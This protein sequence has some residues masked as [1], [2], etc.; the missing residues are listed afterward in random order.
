MWRWQ[1][2]E[3][4]PESLA[5]TDVKSPIA[6]PGQILV[7]VGAVSLNYRDKVAL[8]GGFGTGHALPVVPCSDAAGTVVAVGAGVHRFRIG[9]R[10]ISHLAPRWLHGSVRLPEDD[11]LLGIPLEGVL[12]EQIVLSAEGAVATPR[13]MDDRE[14]CTLPIAALT[15]WCAWFERCHLQ[16]G[17]TVVIQGTGG[18][19]LFALQFA[20]MAGACT[21]VTSSDNQKLE[22]VSALGARHTINYRLEPRWGLA[23]KAL[24]EGV[25]V[26][27]VLN[28]AGGASVMESL[29]ACRAGGSIVIAGL[30]EDAEF[31]LPILPFILQQG[32]IHTLSVGSR[33]AFEAM[34]RALEISE[35]KPVI[36]R[37]FLFSEAKAAF[38][39][40]ERGAFGKIVIRMSS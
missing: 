38:D 22:R 3:Y 23:A 30:L 19:A 8:E 40:L 9:D 16:P 35:I 7:R 5:L 18:V 29:S 27:H 20:E 15:A 36:G 32:T 39:L 2:T 31:T 11:G 21:I 6:G 14:A 34:N 10:V 37:E 26:D 4:S 17:Q 25:G 1:A 12:A 24:T 33:D 13:Y 28:V